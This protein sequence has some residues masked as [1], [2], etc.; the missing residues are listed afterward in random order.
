M[1][2]E[3]STRQR[4]AILRALEEAEHPMEPVELLAIA[5]GDVPRLGI[6]TVYRAIRDLVDEGTLVPVELP[7]ASARY[8]LAGRDH[9]HHFHCRL[10]GRVYEVAG[11]PGDLSHLAPAGFSLEGHEVVLY[12]H[13][14]SCVA[15]RR[16]GR[17]VTP[18][19][20]PARGR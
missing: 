16:A 18:G 4:A 15:A 3:R 20:T 19:V 1:A 17:R 5:R 14:R 12:G 2:L 7:G 9:H 8:E 10:C 13:C 6:A 11:C